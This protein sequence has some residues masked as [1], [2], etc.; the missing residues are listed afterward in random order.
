MA[1][2]QPSINTSGVTHH[3]DVARWRDLVAFFWGQIQHSEEVDYALAVMWG[4]SGGN[5]D[6]LGRVIPTSGARAV[7]LFQ[8]LDYYWDER[9]GQAQDFWRQRGVTINNDP[10]DPMTNIAVAAWL[11]ARGGWGHW[12]VTYDWYKP[13]SFGPDTYWDGYQ[14][15]NLL[16]QPTA[17]PPRGDGQIAGPYLQQQISNAG[18]FM[19]PVKGAV[20]PN[21]SAWSD[22]NE[23]M[24]GVPRSHGQHNGIDIGGSAGTYIRA[25]AS[26]VVERAYWSDQGG[27]YV[28]WVRHDNGWVT[29]YMHLGTKD[30]NFPAFGPGI[31]QG[32]RVT[33]GQLIG[34]MGDT[35]NPAAG[36]YH[37]HFEMHQPGIGPV[38]PMST[39]IF[40]T[41]DY[42][43]A[44]AASG[45]PL[46]GRD[47]YESLF[48]GMVDTLS[49]TRAGGARPNWWSEAGVA[50]PQDMPD[51]GD[52][53]G[54]FPT[55]EYQVQRASDVQQND[56]LHSQ[57]IPIVPTPAPPPAPPPP[58]VQAAE[59]EEEEGKGP[60]LL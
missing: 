27:G 54:D 44:I 6:A 1:A 14:Y 20:P 57:N 8:H 41:P 55:Y 22:G 3:P 45:E 10:R 51:E 5:P 25:A 19:L 9:I 43:E 31:K 48:F 40:E 11:R 34:F 24:F 16:I 18:M 26:G 15:Q 36:A 23:G 7:G 13:G 21:Q 32:A 4:E 52:D 60:V 2:P 35:G 42:S 12:S 47:Y 38:D 39:G 46:S 58:N 29:K 53:E 30:G 37:L 28:V 56:A 50:S 33:Q 59:E 49:K 17:T